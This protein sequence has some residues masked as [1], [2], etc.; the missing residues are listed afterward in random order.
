[1]NTTIKKSNIHKDI[2]GTFHSMLASCVKVKSKWD[3]ETTSFS[4][5]HHRQNNPI[6]E[7]TDGR[8]ALKVQSDKLWN[9]NFAGSVVDPKTFTVID[10]TFPSVDQVI[11]DKADYTK[12]DFSIPSWIGKLAKQDLFSLGVIIQKN[13]LNKAVVNL[14]LL[15][16]E[17]DY[18]CILKPEYLSLFAGFTVELWY[19]NVNGRNKPI[20][21]EVPEL[22]Q[23]VDELVY[24]V[25]PVYKK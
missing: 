10:T 12:I 2:Q 17:D 23:Y 20:I 22:L 13:H 24:V 6:V 9:P 25:M 14:E 19:A 16:P 5:I 21:I 15:H 7:S 3:K 1:M 18:I 8:R 4:G 11:P